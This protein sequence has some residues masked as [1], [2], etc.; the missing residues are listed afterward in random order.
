MAISYVAFSSAVP[1]TLTQVEP[2]GVQ[3]GDF[4]LAVGTNDYAEL[5]GPTG[6]TQVGTT[7]VEGFDFTHSSV[8]FHKR[9]PSA[10]SLTWT[11]TAANYACVVILAFRGVEGIDVSAE[12][13]NASFVAPSVTAGYDNSWMV[14]STASSQW[15]CSNSP[16][17]GTTVI[18][19]WGPW[20]N[21]YK[22]VDAGATGTVTFPYFDD[23]IVSRSIV[24]RPEPE[25]S[26]GNMLLMF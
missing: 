12:S 17:S 21:A 7:V 23:P 2:T 4:Y 3:E 1:D 8:W 11:T 9:G 25:P 14:V 19:N 6:W 5:T 15:D 16:P 26:S 22:E 20:L 13:A 10:P 24:L 18:G